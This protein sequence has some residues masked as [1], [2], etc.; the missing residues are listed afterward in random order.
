ML[1][2]FEWEIKHILRGENTRAKNLAKLASSINDSGLGLI[3]VEVL[4]KAT[5]REKSCYHLTWGDNW[6]IEIGVYLEGIN[7]LGD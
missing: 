5:I 2:S 6:R 1:K 3:I 4:R 7:L